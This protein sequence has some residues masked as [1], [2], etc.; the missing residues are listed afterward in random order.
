MPTQDAVLLPPTL[1]SVAEAISFAPLDVRKT[2]V[3]KMEFKL[4]TTGDPRSLS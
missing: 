1:S 2:R 4:A 3:R